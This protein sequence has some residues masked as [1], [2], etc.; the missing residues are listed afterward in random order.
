MWAVDLDSAVLVVAV[1]VL[2]AFPCCPWRKVPFDRAN[3]A[4][5]LRK[6]PETVGAVW[7]VGLMQTTTFTRDSR[8]RLFPERGTLEGPAEEVVAM[9][10]VGFAPYG[11]LDGPALL[12]ALMVEKAVQPIASAE[13]LACDGFFETDEELAEFLG[14]YVDERAKDVA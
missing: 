10:A 5:R 12:E 6:R 9:S 7:T 2:L 3:R 4:A 1:S 14:W 8:S 11:V 13:D